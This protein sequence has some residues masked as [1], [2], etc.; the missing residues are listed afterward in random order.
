[1]RPPFFEVPG[2]LIDSEAAADIIGIHPKTL[3]A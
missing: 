3:G 2:R 1:M